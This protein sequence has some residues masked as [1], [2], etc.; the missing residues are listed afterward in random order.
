MNSRLS[1]VLTASA[2]VSSVLMGF[3][4]LGD[5][6]KP[7]IPITAASNDC[8]SYTIDQNPAGAN[9]QDDL[10][11]SALAV[12]DFNGDGVDDLAIGAPGED[13]ND[14]GPNAGVVFI[15]DS[16][17]SGTGEIEQLASYSGWRTSWD[18]II[19]GQF[20]GDD[21]TDLLFYN[22][23]AGVG[24]FYTTDGLGGLTELATNRGW[25]GIW[26]LIIP[27]NFDDA[28]YTDLLLYDRDTEKGVFYATD[29]AGNMA[30][31]AS[32]SGWRASWNLIIPGNFNGD[33]YTD[34]LFY[35]RSAGEGE[36]YATNGTGE[37][38]QLGSHSGWRKTWDMIIPGQFDS[39]GHTDLL[40]YDRST[41]EGE[42]YASD[43]A[44]G[45]SKLATNS[46]WRGTWELIIPGQFDG[47]TYT[48]LLFYDRAAGD[49]QFYAANGEGGIVKLAAHTGWRGTWDSIIPGSYGGNHLTDLLY[50]DGSAGEGN[51]YISSNPG[52]AYFIHQE[53]VGGN[54][55]DDRFGSTL[56]AGDFNGD[57]IDDLAVGVP[58]EDYQDSGPDAGV[59]F[60]FT[61][62][63]DGLGEPYIIDQAPHGANEAGDLFGSALATGDF[64]DDG[65]DDLAI[66]V[67]EVAYEDFGANVGW[68]YVANGSPDGLNDSYFVDQTPAGDNEADDKFGAS[69][70]VGDFNADGIADLVVSAPGEDYQGSGPDAGVVFVFSGSTDGL[71]EPYFLDQEPLGDNEEGDLF[72]STL[73]AGDF[74][75]DHVDDLAIGVMEA[76]YE[77]FGANV[78]WVYIANGSPD[79]LGDSYFVNQTPAGDNEAEDKFASALTAGDFNMDGIDDLAASAPGED[80]R[81]S[82]PDAGVV[83]V[84]TG[85]SEGVENPYFIHQEPFGSN[86][87][88]DHFGAAMA[89]GD[90]NGDGLDE[91]AIGVPNEEFENVGPNVGGVLIT[92]VQP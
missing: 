47:D 31:L 86:E 66:G 80:Y 70:V 9:E 44:G 41:R 74:N 14:S 34:L 11:G 77:D 39:D 88:G 15:F 52:P 40:F 48:D 87:S 21:H 60:I 55:S 25:R 54:E 22:R 6:A 37:M 76:A 58:G 71:G 17:Q 5:E 67:M 62:S 45:V 46:G 82:G 85:S 72:G 73:A 26:D 4:I 8:N 61:G 20:G 36:F 79:G 30:K 83:F 65:L 50:Y 53:P 43:G 7:S 63:P 75:A 33:E 32:H 90:F 18:L 3:I 69:L 64:N 19:P 28:G 68:V 29:G 1:R 56:A 35:D 49:G 23:S 16:S 91:L 59:V 10:F 92:C 27:G 57:G 81:D 38:T 12:G 51:I 24:Q 42:F 2:F 84:F 89:A 13:Y 78:G